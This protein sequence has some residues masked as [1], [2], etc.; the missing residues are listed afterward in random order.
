MMSIA[1]RARASWSPPA[2]RGLSHPGRGA[3][4]GTSGSSNRPDPLSQGTHLRQEAQLQRLSSCRYT[5]NESSGAET[6]N[7]HGKVFS[8]RNTST[9]SMSDQSRRSHWGCTLG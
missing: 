3:T 4:R 7:L 8:I 2:A 6:V 5:T 9:N 1:L